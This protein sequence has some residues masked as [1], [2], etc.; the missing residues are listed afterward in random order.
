MVRNAV[1]VAL[2]SQTGGEILD[3][4]KRLNISPTVILT[5]NLRKTWVPGVNVYKCDTH[6]NIMDWLR[7]S[8]PES[9]YRQKVIITLHGYL[10]ILPQDICERY[11]IYN[12]HPAAIELYPELKGKDPQVRTW[13]NNE[14]YRI[15]GSVVHEVTP[16]VD[17]GKIVSSVCYTNRVD[18]LQEMYSKLKQSSIESWEWFMRKKLCE[19]EL[20][21][22]SQ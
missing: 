12:G 5:N 11:S 17:D 20:L 16:V 22:R 21:E 15:I 6:D 7:K 18:S 13:D 10:R 4:S 8:Y 19:L 1:W 3:L 9:N 14:K 2:F